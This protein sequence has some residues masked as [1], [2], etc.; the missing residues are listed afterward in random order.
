MD[1][2]FK[3]GLVQAIS[4]QSDGWVDAQFDLCAWAGPT[5]E[6]AFD[7]LTDG[8]LAMEG[9]YV[10]DLRLEVD[11]Y[12]TLIDNAEGTSSFAFQGFTKTVASTKP[13]TITCCNGAATMTLTKA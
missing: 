10:D 9:L 3:S 6:L 8:G 11:G 4:G 1:D 13:I 7:Y 12:Q 5:V 2:P